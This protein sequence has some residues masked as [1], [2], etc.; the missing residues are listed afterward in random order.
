MDEAGTTFVDTHA[1]VH[2]MA[3]SMMLIVFVFRFL[4]RPAVPKVF[5][6]PATCPLARACGAIRSRYTP[7][8]QVAAAAV[9]H[10]RA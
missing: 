7:H 6:S 4:P 3:F 5:K 2:F 1:S 8:P 10:E 9:A